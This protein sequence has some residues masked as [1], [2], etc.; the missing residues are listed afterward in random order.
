MVDCRV[1]AN[2]Q[3]FWFPSKLVPPL[4]LPG[5]EDLIFTDRDHRKFGGGYVVPG[6]VRCV[7]VL[8]DSENP[9]HYL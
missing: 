5:S 6:V 8:D 1:P 9:S 4:F 3:K 7:L 2:K